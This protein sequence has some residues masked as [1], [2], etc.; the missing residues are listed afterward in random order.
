VECQARLVAAYAAGRYRLPAR[1]VMERVIAEDEQKFLG[2]FNHTPRHTQQ[3]DFFIYEHDLR[4]KELPDG[5]R[6]AQSLGAPVLA[7]GLG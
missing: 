2:H 7:G 4:T 6:R 1:D 5:L 3:V